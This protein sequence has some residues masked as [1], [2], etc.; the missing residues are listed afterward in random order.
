MNQRI[1][2]GLK[3][4][5]DVELID[6]LHDLLINA[7]RRVAQ[8]LQIKLHAHQQGKTL[9]LESYPPVT[10]TLRSFHRHSHHCPV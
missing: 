9:R 3:L 2:L 1:R 6:A 10:G 8:L 4:V 7:I 5:A